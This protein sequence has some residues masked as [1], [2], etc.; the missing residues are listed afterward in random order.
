MINLTVSQTP[1]S[2]SRSFTFIDKSAASSIHNFVS[3]F[4]FFQLAFF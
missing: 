4:T 2:L 3:H 1:L